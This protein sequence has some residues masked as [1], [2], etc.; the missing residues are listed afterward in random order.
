MFKGGL[1]A[2][3]LIDKDGDGAPDTKPGFRDHGKDKHEIAVCH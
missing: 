3:K 2:H 1:V